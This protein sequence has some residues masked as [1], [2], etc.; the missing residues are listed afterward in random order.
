M[1]CLIVA[2]PAPLR[3]DPNL[4]GVTISGQTSWK[5]PSGYL[6]GMMSP[7]LPFFGTCSALPLQGTLPPVVQRCLPVYRRG[8]GLR[9]A[10]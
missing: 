7:N 6:P 1:H 8:V 2:P 4:A 9:A 5:N 3:S 10:G